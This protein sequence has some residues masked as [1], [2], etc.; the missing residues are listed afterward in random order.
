MYHEKARPVFVVKRG[1]LGTFRRF[2]SPKDAK[3]YAQV[4]RKFNQ[5]MDRVQPKYFDFHPGEILLHEGKVLIERVF[6]GSNYWQL[7]EGDA[8]SKYYRWFLR[9]TKN[10]GVDIR[11]LQRTA[12]SVVQ[13]ASSFLVDFQRIGKVHVDVGENNFVFLDY[14]PLTGRPLIS[15]V[16]FIHPM[17]I[18][19][20]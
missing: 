7:I 6:P 9:R 17:S 15:I 18:G 5:Y 3:L 14:N 13:E 8:N 4:V 11:N 10:K 19:Q 2:S 1:V 16:D 12:K 20:E